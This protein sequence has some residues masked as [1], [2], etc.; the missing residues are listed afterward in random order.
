MATSLIF[1]KLSFSN[2]GVYEYICKL[3]IMEQELEI[4]K[5]HEDKDFLGLD[6]MVRLRLCLAIKTIL[7]YFINIHKERKISDN[8]KKGTKK[9]ISQVRF[10]PISSFI[11]LSYIGDVIPFKPCITAFKGSL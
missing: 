3:F 7:N 6:L 4:F 11:L 1:S 2:V 5:T 10:D 8:R 9:L